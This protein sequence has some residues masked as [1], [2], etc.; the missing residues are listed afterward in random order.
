M[1]K[2]ERVTLTVTTDGETYERMT[3]QLDLLIGEFDLVVDVRR[4]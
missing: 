1:N 3:R 2:G 4:E